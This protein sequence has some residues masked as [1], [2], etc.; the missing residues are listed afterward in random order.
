MNIFMLSNYSVITGFAECHKMNPTYFRMQL[1]NSITFEMLHSIILCLK[2]IFLVISKSQI[3]IG[4]VIKLKFRAN[5]KTAWFKTVHI[6]IFNILSYLL[7]QTVN[8]ENKSLNVLN[9]IS[10]V[11][12]IWSAVFSLVRPNSI[13]DFI[14]IKLMKAEFYFNLLSWNSKI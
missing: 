10:T 5:W 14:E 1:I 6:L 4:F 3:T 8:C 13:Y 7:S 11:E 2:L 9:K 12:I